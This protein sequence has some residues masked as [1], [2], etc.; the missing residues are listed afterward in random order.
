MA[1]EVR[2]PQLGQT[3]EEGTIVN[4]L[5]KVG[6][7][8]KKGD[9]IFEIETDKATLEMESPA[10]GFVKYVL[11]EVDQTLPVGAPLLVVGDKDEDVPQSFVDSLEGS[12]G[13]P[14]V[15]EPAPAEPAPAVESAPP[16]PVAEAT[17][18]APVAEAAPAAPPVQPQPTEPKVEAPTPERI[19]A[20]P[21]AKKLAEQLGVALAAVTGTGPAGRITEQDVKQAASS[22]PAKPAPVQK[23]EPSPKLGT[24]LPLN[25][26]QKITGQRMVQSK[27][28]IPC[29]YLSVKA[30][31]TDLVKFRTRLNRASDVKVAYNDFIMRAVAMGL[32]KFPVMT[33]QLAGETIQL[34]DSIGVGLA[35]S[36][37]GGLVAP[38]VKDVNKKDV[39]QI[40]R[41]SKALIEKARSNKLA[42]TD[43]E[44]GCIT[45]SNLGAFE[46]E[47]F[48]P[49]VVPGQC[50]ILGIGKISETCVPESGNIM[51]RKLMSMVLSIDHKVTNGAYAAEFL[52]YVRKLLEDTST[53]SLES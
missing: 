36:V 43:L 7:E 13:A 19:K 47:S 52:D 33:G 53:F 29:F 8:V 26:L 39:R 51:V 4:C 3:M 31:V 20:S 46:I 48:I 1:K 49:I 37:P 10:E 42:P 2:L 45:V 44:G 25:R 22:K 27:H 5:V 12:A 35:I 16:A 18:A 28:E 9:V 40:A 30:D 21:R 11:T 24:A 41:D 23:T 50:S 15:T 32:E 6:D 38:I 17:P 14:A 34:A